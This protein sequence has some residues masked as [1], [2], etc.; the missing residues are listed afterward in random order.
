MLLLVLGL[1]LFLGAHTLPILRDRRAGL[2]DRLGQGGYRGLFTALSLAGLVL[3]V[4]GYGAARSEGALVLWDPPRWTRHLAATLM[5]PV[6]ILLAVPRRP[7]YIRALVK[8]PM[9]LAV[10]IW[11]TA[12]LVANGTL[13]DLLL[14]GGFLAWAVV[15][16][17]SVK[18]RGEPNPPPS[19]W[20][21]GDTV[22]VLAGLVL[23]GAFVWRLHLWLIGV[24][25]V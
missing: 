13:P 3:I 5:I 14:F 15:D 6:F 23:Y 17:I 9:L 21:R 4:W 22:A 25:P 1:V 2:I 18:R 7:G 16:R 11:A 20:T 12:H 19:P 10:K 8:H 24:S